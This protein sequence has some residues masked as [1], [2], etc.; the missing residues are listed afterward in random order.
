[1]KQVSS[2]LA[3]NSF[4]F[5]ERKVISPRVGDDHALIVELKKD[6][7]DQATCNQL[8]RYRR[9]WAACGIPTTLLAVG[10]SVTHSDPQV[11]S[12]QYRIDRP[13]R[14]VILERN[15]KLWRCPARMGG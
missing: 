3:R 8:K 5:S 13:G 10:A 15:G 1:M 12:Y 11:A 14:S 2:S 4:T 6:P 7:A 9:Y